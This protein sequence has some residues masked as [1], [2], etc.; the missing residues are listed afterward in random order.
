MYDKGE[1]PKIDGE[2]VS[3]VERF[4]RNSSG[5]NYN[6]HVTV[7]V[8][9]EDFVKQLKAEPFERFSFEPAGVAIYQFG[10]F[11]TAQKEVV[12]MEVEMKSHPASKPSSESASV[13]TDA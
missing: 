10:N 3:Y 8:A 5:E 13:G 11:G 7:G 2:I 9:H 12:G 1:L 4:A 6:P